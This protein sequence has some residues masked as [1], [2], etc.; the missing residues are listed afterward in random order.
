MH[1]AIGK[2]EILDTYFKAK[3]EVPTKEKNDKKPAS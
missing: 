3:P 2:K 1:D